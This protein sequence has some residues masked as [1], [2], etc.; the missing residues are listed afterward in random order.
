MSSSN[1]Q[2]EHAA[3]ILEEVAKQADHHT[4]LLVLGITGLLALAVLVVPLASR[5]KLPFTVM[6]AAVG[7]VIGLG[8][9]IILH[10]EWLGFLHEFI[11]ALHS[12]E[13]TSEAVFFIFLP[14]LVFESAL[15]ID[16]R[17][18][19]DDIAPILMLAVLGLLISTG[20]I[21][22]TMASITGYSILV[23]LLLGAIVSATDPVAVVAIFKDL[24]A[25]KRLAILVEG[26]SLFNDAT[27]IVAFTILSAM[28]VG[29][30]DPT[31]L[32]GTGAFIKVFFGG[33]LVGYVVARITCF[34]LTR[35]GDSNLPKI[36]LTMSLAYLAFII[37]EHNLHVSGVMAVVT[38]ALVLGSRGRSV[39]PQSAWHGLE[40]VW[41]QIG[42]I[43]NSVIF[44][45][46]GLAVP[47]ILAGMGTEQFI[48]LAVLLVVAFTTRFVIIFG[49]VPAMH[50]MGWAA[51]VSTGYRAVM[52]WGGLR[53]AVSL[54][55]ALAVMENSAFPVAVQQFIGVLV[56]GFVLFTL[57]IN[58]TTVS[59]VMRAFGLDKLSAADMAIRDR[60]YA[61]AMDSVGE[62]V[63]ATARSLDADAAFTESVVAPYTKLASAG[64]GVA[65]TP[66]ISQDDWLLIGLRIISMSENKA[67]HKMFDQGEISPEIA[68]IL[69]SQGADVRDSLK[70]GGLEDYIGNYQE[71]LAFDWQTRLGARAQRTLGRS[72][73]LTRRLAA[74]FGTLE[75]SC[76][77][78]TSLSTKGVEQ[79]RELI[80]AQA[81][82]KLTDV[83]QQRTEQTRRALDSLRAA[84]PDYAAELEKRNLQQTAMR[85]E[86]GHYKDMLANSL[87]GKEVY[88][89]LLGEMTG[90]YQNLQESLSLD[91]G[92]DAE[93]LVA[94]VPF[95]QSLDAEAQQNI[96]AMLKPRLVLPGEAV[97]ELGGPPDAMYFISSGAVRVPLR[98]GEV[99]LGS[100]DFFGE[101]ALLWDNPRMASVYAEGFCELLTLYTRDFERLLAEDAQVKSVIEEVAKERREIAKR[102]L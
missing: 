5:L 46:V 22:F 78:L 11:E 48:W 89:N 82:E 83:L 95:F 33:V 77:V 12:M 6:L 65:E 21:G 18:L 60:V 2:A 50:K 8:S 4:M 13:I 19:L 64:A 75:A 10:V 54:A 44:V 42:F 96:A 37:A 16:V 39:I 53:G 31:V 38:A 74:R 70:S 90:R 72:Q 100:G 41:E 93:K 85:L 7:I 32:S 36:T 58:A 17:R 102:D 87:I 45:L 68:R 35:I 79:V 47:T 71:K 23:C 73:L 88:S 80:G 84:Y 76:S 43:A 97:F 15:A 25:P 56:T 67:Y 9:E 34:L 29:E 52:F 14:A 81:T 66:Q 20:A 55:L 27:A 91:L 98:D 59:V 26:E 63:R 57:A 92:L 61:S 40:E 69:F 30:S 62:S 49:L 94:K 1:T 51:D 99:I 28:I 24:G 86:Q 3:E 101:L